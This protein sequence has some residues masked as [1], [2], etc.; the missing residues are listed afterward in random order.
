MHR[1]SY[2]KNV[3]FKIKIHKLDTMPYV[4]PNGLETQPNRESRY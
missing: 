4:F 3:Y 1:Q 2:L